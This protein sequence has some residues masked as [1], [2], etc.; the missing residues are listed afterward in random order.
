MLFHNFS[1]RLF[2][3]HLFRWTLYKI[4]HRIVENE[5]S[6]PHGHPTIR[7]NLHFNF[8]PVRD[9]GP[10]SSV[11]M[12][13]GYGLDGPGIENRWG[14]RWF[15]NVQTGPGTQPASCT[16]GTGFFPG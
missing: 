4:K 1:V 9:R 6:A 14:A 16:M 15:V 7:V 8:H 12:A 2:A 13:T 5:A 10:G 11:D 3:F